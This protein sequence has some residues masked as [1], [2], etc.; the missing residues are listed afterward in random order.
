MEAAENLRLEVGR[1][2]WRVPWE[3]LVLV[4]NHGWKRYARSAECVLL[5]DLRKT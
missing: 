1:L 3:A 2:T 5:W 4:T